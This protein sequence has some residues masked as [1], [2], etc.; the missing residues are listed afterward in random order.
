MRIALAISCLFLAAPAVSE[1]LSFQGSFDVSRDAAL[2]ITQKDAR[3][4]GTFRFG[5][6]A[7]TGRIEIGVTNSGAREATYA[8][9]GLALPFGSIDVGRPRSIMDIGPMPARS[10]FAAEDA[11]RPLAAEAALD[12]TLGGGVRI[13]GDHGGFQIGSS[14]HTLDGRDDD[15]VGIAG[16]FD[17]EDMQP[18]DRIVVYGGLE[19]DGRDER[20]RLGTEVSRGPTVA[21]L[22]VVR[23]SDDGGYSVGQI[24]LGLAVNEALTLGV[25]GSQR[26]ERVGE[27]GDP[28][29]GIGAEIDTGSGLF[30][31]GGLDGASRDDYAVDLS[32]GFQF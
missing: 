29:F 22:D 14:F 3:A 1:P 13:I 7:L 2:E 17:L 31:S 18:A 4:Q 25:S 24:S 8:S 12:H 26:F 20:F 16:R 23:A 9:A 10:R 30:V 19:S 28:R 5:G 21:T 11:L 15:I 6:A 27:N 32:V